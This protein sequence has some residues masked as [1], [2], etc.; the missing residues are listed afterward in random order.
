MPEDEIQDFEIEES[1]NM[2]KEL[3]RVNNDKP[4]QSCQ[5]ALFEIKYDIVEKEKLQNLQR[6]NI[7]LKNKVL[8]LQK[9]LN[10]YKRNEKYQFWGY[11]DFISGSKLQLKACHPEGN[12]DQI[13]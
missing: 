11:H 4:N 6:E 2:Q 10:V 8:D 7:K 5:L 1:L 13:T 9:R 12:I 3:D